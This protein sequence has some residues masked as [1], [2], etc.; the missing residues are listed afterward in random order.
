MNTEKAPP[1]VGEIV[2]KAW[3]NNDVPRVG[4]RVVLSGQSNPQ[5]ALADYI[6]GV[7]ELTRASTANAKCVLCGH[8]R[9]TLFTGMCKVIVANDG[10]TVDGISCGCHCEF[11][12]TS[13]AAREAAHEIVADAQHII[14]GSDDEGK[15]LVIA[16]IILKHFPVSGDAGKSRFEIIREQ[17]RSGSEEVTAIMVSTETCPSCNHLWIQHESKYGCAELVA[18]GFCGCKFDGDVIS[19]VEALLIAETAAREY[20]SKSL[21]TTTPNEDRNDAWQRGKGAEMVLDRLRALPVVQPAAGRTKVNVLGIHCFH[22]NQTHSK[23][24]FCDEELLLVAGKSDAKLEEIR[25][26]R[27]K[28][29]SAVDVCKCRVCLEFVKNA[30]DDVGYLLSLLDRFMSPVQP[31]GG[32]ATGPHYSCCEHES[33]EPDHHKGCCIHG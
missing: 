12:T 33:G 17:Q 6:N 21:A 28:A 14:E 4:D 30:R 5:G 26:R 1:T 7:I 8:E 13:V 22:C 19:R 3:F 23:S 24:L 31:A 32:E 16:A 20:V 11:P 15:R 29:G 9:P 2:A 25:N 27:G 18:P 10:R